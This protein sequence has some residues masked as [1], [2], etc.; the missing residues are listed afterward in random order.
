MKKVILEMI[1]YAYQGVLSH[2]E[3]PLIFHEVSSEEP[4][5]YRNAKMEFAPSSHPVRNFAIAIHAEGRKYA[6]SGDG[7]FNEHTA[8]LYQ[9]CSL[10]VHESYS[11]DEEEKGH[12]KVVDLL[13]MARERNVEKLALTHIQRD[14]RKNRMNEIK[15]LTRDCGL[16]VIIPNVGDVLEI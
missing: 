2:F 8:K 12:A 7:N 11:I 3:F 14:L 10:L 1:D 4:F 5:L 15:N 16:P 13:K 9:G 6:Y